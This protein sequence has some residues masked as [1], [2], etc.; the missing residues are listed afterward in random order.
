MGDPLKCVVRI[1]KSPNTRCEE[2][3]I[4]GDKLTVVDSNNRSNKIIKNI[5]K[6]Y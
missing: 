2:V 3:R 1:K 6:Q 4:I 5:K